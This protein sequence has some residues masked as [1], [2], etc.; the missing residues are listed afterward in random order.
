MKQYKY[1][2]Y[3]A[4]NG[5]YETFEDFESAKEWIT[6]D[7]GDGFGE[8]TCNGQSYIAKIT[9]RTNYEVTDRV[10]NYHEHTDECPTY[11]DKEEWPYGSEFTTVGKIILKEV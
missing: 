10:E 3:E 6:R 9:H 8:E 2:A 4:D 11:C 5:E 7:N 1:V